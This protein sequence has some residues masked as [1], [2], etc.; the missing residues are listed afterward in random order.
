DADVLLVS[1]GPRPSPEQR[2]EA[3]TIC[4]LRVT[5]LP[6][7]WLAEAPAQVAEAAYCLAAIA[8]EWGADS[9]HL[10][11]PALAPE[12]R[13]PAPVVAVAHSCVGTWWRAVRGNQPMPPDLAWRA[14]LTGIGLRTADAAIA[15]SRAL[16]RDLAECYGL[17]RPVHAIHNGRRAN[18][19]VPDRDGFALTAGRLWDEAKNIRTLDEAAARC[20]FHI[21]AAGPC[22]GPNGAMIACRTLRLLGR[23]DEAALARAYAS[24]RVFV[25]VAR[26]EPFGLAVLEAAQ[27]GCA[28]VLSDIPTFRELWDGA[29]LFVDPEDPDAVARALDTAMR[30]SC[31]ADAARDR[32][33][34][35]SADAM[36]AATL[37]LHAALH[38]APA[39]GTA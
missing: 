1:M 5:D 34:V 12:A 2:A 25:S 36:T 27:S 39:L 7:D 4:A 8:A 15:P 17:S 20:A 24:A 21:R 10:H 14:R 19:A 18:P 29:A 6:L 33:D 22:A 26:Y 37:R 35:Y 9:V 13:W 31:L 3:E 23:L 32:A 38:R 30:E 28:L 11:A 16:A